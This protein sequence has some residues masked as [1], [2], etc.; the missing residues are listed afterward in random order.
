MK[1]AL[2]RISWV[3]LPVALLFPGVAAAGQDANPQQATA[4]GNP[5]IPQTGGPW[6]DE[7][8]KVAPAGKMAS[9]LLQRAF[10]LTTVIP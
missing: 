6:A 1:S 4:S 8:R 10:Y 7:L 5:P 9:G 3:P 2:L